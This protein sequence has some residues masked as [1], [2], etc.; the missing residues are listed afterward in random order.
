MRLTVQRSAWFVEDFEQQGRWY[1]R[2]ATEAVAA[3]YLT[4]LHRTVDLLSQQPG[5]GRQRHFRHPE[6]RGLRSFRIEQPFSKHL[7]FYRYDDK[8]LIVERVMY[9]GRNLPRRLTEPPNE[10]GE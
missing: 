2:H 4:S 6:L 1:A 10:S 8:S 9:G 3:R 5:F 7:I